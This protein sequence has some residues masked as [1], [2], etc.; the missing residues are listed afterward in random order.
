MNGLRPRKVVLNR[1]TLTPKD[2]PESIQAIPGHP[3]RCQ[4]VVGFH[5]RALHVR[6]RRLA[7]AGTPCPPGTLR[8]SHLAS[9]E[10]P[11]QRHPPFFPLFLNPISNHMTHA[12]VPGICPN[13]FSECL[14]ISLKF[15][16]QTENFGKYFFGQKNI[17]AKLMGGGLNCHLIFFVRYL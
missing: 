6:G 1:K 3:R 14:K 17:T 15:S 4:A 11:I 8:H 16:G 7:H 2:V 9:A 5:T 13:G 12:D 10:A